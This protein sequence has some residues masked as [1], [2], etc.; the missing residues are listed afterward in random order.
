[1]PA[2]SSIGEAVAY[3]VKG[4]QQR[5]LDPGAVLAVAAQEGIGGGI[6]DNGTSFGPFQLHKG[7]AYPSSAPQDPQQ[8]NAWAWSSEGI[9]YALN[10]IQRV[11]GGQKGSAAISSIVTGFERPQNPQAEYNGAI[12]SYPQATLQAQQL[13]SAKG[14]SSS[15]G[16]G[17]A[18]ILGGWLQKHTNLP[19]WLISG[20]L[21]GNAPGEAKQTVSDAEAVADFLGKLTDAGFVLRVGQVVAGAVLVLLGIYLLAR[22][23]GLAPSAPAP[24]QAAAAAVS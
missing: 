8:A 9:D 15:G 14:S 13:I 6:G 5:G 3:I 11:A 18:G 12:A 17:N 22:V 4:A 10:A 23:V 7:G 1:M 21:V 16:G 19:S 2:F 20:G 24:V